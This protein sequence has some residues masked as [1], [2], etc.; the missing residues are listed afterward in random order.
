[1][2]SS[3]AVASNC[4]GLDGS[5]A[6]RELS[7]LP[8]AAG[9]IASD[10]TGLHRGGAA[11]AVASDWRYG[12]AATLV[13]IRL[14]SRSGIRLIAIF[15]LPS[16][17]EYCELHLWRCESSLAREQRNASGQTTHPPKFLLTPTAALISI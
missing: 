11:A 5:P 15:H 12:S 16:G 10:C 13:S 9:P 17:I 7:G 8:A 2:T 4:A 14:K 3:A 1:M 6:R